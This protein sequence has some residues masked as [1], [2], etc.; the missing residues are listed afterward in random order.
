LN[1]LAELTTL[2]KTLSVIINWTCHQDES[3]VRIVAIGG[4]EAVVKVMQTFPK[5]QDLQVNASHSLVNLTA[6]CNVGITKAIEAGGVEVLL[7]AVNNHLNS[8]YVCEHACWALYNIMC[9]TKEN[10]GLLIDLGNGAAV[11]KVRKEWPDNDHLQTMV[12][13][14]TMFIVAEMN[15]WVDEE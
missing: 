3:R 15:A 1:E 11:S 14:L 10:A 8:A 12:R 13:Y 4:V 5:C 9:G 6:S 2:F 7:A